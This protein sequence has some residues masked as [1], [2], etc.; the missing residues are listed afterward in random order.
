MSPK[1]KPEHLLVSS[2]QRALTVGFETLFYNMFAVGSD[3][4]FPF[5]VSTHQANQKVTHLFGDF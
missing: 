5:P 3:S 4:C 2:L 1:A